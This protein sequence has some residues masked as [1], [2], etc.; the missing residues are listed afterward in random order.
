MKIWGKITGDVAKAESLAYQCWICGME[1][2]NPTA[3]LWHIHACGL[4]TTRE[5]VIMVKSRVV[6]T[7]AKLEIIC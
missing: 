7:A 3:Y 5:S 4:E 1:H 2:N 6:L